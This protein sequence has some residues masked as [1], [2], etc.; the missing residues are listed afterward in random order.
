MSVVNTSP[1]ISF[2]IIS[3]LLNWLKCSSVSSLNPILICLNGHD[4]AGSTLEES[5]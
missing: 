3:F 2:Q 1:T 4:I 5:P